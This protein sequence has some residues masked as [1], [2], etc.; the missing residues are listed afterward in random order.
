LTFRRS[1]H[2]QDV[3]I[4]DDVFLIQ[5]EVA[6]AYKAGRIIAPQD[7]AVAPPAAGASDT[8][9]SGDQSI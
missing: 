1:L 9:F 5:R 8:A 2:P 3:E 4:S 7:A 6:E